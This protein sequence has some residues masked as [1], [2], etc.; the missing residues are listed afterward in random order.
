MDDL[1]QIVPNTCQNKPLNDREPREQRFVFVCHSL[2][3]TIG[4]IKK[5]PYTG[6][7]IKLPEVSAALYIIRV[8]STAESGIA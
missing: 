3:T 1:L 2:K 8:R 5:A 6:A 7:C 4:V